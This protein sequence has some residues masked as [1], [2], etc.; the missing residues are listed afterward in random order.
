MITTLLWCHRKSKQWPSASEGVNDPAGN[1][2]HDLIPFCNCIWISFN[3]NMF[4]IVLKLQGI[5]LYIMYTTVPGVHRIWVKLQ[6][7]LIAVACNLNLYTFKV[8]L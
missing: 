8:S 3:S 7:K 2:S 6:N 5:S 4:M 1:Q